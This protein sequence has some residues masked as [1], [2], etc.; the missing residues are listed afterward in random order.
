MTASLR[1][2]SMM[3]SPKTSITS[4]PE[5]LLRIVFE[6][7]AL[8]QEDIAALRLT[9]HAFV[10]AANSIL[11]R[12]IS[13]SQLYHDRD[14]FITICNSPHLAQHVYEIEWQ[15]ISWFPGYFAQ[16]PDLKRGK[17]GPDREFRSM[18]GTLDLLANQLFWLPA[19][20]LAQPNLNGDTVL[21][22]RDK[23]INRFLGE[24]CKSLQLLPNLCTAISQAMP[25]DRLLHWCSEYP[26][27]V[28]VFQ[29]HHLSIPGEYCAWEYPGSDGLCNFLLP[30]ME[31]LEN[32]P[33]TRLLW[34]DESHGASYLRP[35][36][37]KQGFQNLVSMH[38]SA[39]PK[40][41][42]ENYAHLQACL[43]ACRNVRHLA[44]ELRD[45]FHY[46]TLQLKLLRIDDGGIPQWSR[47]N[48]I[49]LSNFCFLGGYG[50]QLLSL[51]EHSEESLRHLYLQ[52]TKVSFDLINELAKRCPRLSLLSLRI[53]DNRPSGDSMYVPEDIL[54]N[55][56]NSGTTPVLDS[57]NRGFDQRRFNRY[58][59]GSRATRFLFT[60]DGED[61]LKHEWTLEA[62]NES[63]ETDPSEPHLANAPR[64]DF[65]RFYHEDSDRGEV[66]VF[67][68]GQEN[69]HKGYKTDLW[70][71]TNRDGE[72]AYG[73]YPLDWWEDWDP[74]NGD[75]AEPTPYC[76]DLFN[77]AA[78]R[79]KI[80]MAGYESARPPPGAIRY[81][82]EEGELVKRLKR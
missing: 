47:L 46:S 63:N 26:F 34:H 32:R 61:A 48:S 33:I 6:D 11:F 53:W 28:K 5:I 57:G 59:E 23:A 36:P 67:Q 62:E 35:L 49:S 72:V 55:Y 37:S 41:S 30:A 9:C 68:I 73:R 80:F 54:L 82:E 58:L 69:K 81:D 74:D 79:Q 7:D 25:A 22:R 16:L 43:E 15:E 39:N 20:S 8:D 42:K 71:F 65:S 1:Q 52:D 38:L 31:S 2:L 77:F 12:R 76:D 51:I 24:F 13:I 18:M 4:L 10:H 66:W 64:W 75:L 50:R 3:A 78:E 29:D 56:V 14:R 17:E 45:C 19:L 70:K 44:L 27:E 60:F 40:N 21:I